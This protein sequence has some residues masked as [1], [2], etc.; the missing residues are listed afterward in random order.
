LQISVAVAQTLFV[1]VGHTSPGQQSCPLPPH[2]LHVVVALSQTN[3]SP[4]TL[5]PCMFEQHASPRPPHAAHVPAL[6]VLNGAVHPTPPVQHAS[7]MPPHGDP[8]PGT[9]APAVHVPSPPPHAAAAA[10]HVFVLWSQQPPPLQRLPSQHAA[11][12]PPQA[13]H[14]P[15]AAPVQVSPATVQKLAS[16]PLP[17]GLPGQHAMVFVPQG[18]TEPIPVPPVHERDGE[19]PPFRH[20][21][22]VVSPHEVPAAMHWPSTQQSLPDPAQPFS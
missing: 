8:V 5:W 14:V 21:P 13:P 1:L 16:E 11:P 12:V 6:H 17:F 22:S 2:A 9:H 19:P 4:Q 18:F 10:T 3:G 7:P 15:P 20:V